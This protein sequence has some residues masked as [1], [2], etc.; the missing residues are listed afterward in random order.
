[1]EI[2]GPIDQEVISSMAEWL[3]DKPS[4]SST[5]NISGRTDDKILESFILKALKLGEFDNELAIQEQ[6]KI[7]RRV[8]QSTCDDVWSVPKTYAEA[9]RSEHAERWQ[10]A[11]R[12]ELK[13]ME[14]MRVWEVC[15][16][17]KD[18]RLTDAKWVFA[19]KHDAD[20]NP[21]KFK[22]RYV[23]KGFSQIHGVDFTDTFAP[24]A[25]FSALRILITIAAHFGWEIFSFDVTAAYL[26]SDLDHTVYVKQPTGFRLGPPG[27][28]LKCLKALYGTKQAGRCWWKFIA[29]KLRNLGFEPSQFDA[30]FYVLRR[31]KDVCMIWLH[32]DD[33]SVTGSSRSLIKEIEDNLKQHIKIKW[34]EGLKSIVGLKVDKISPHKYKLSQTQLSKKILRDNEDLI[35]SLS[36]STPM[37]D[38]TILTTI[39]KEEKE[40]INTSRYL[41]II[42]SMSY[43]AVGTR[44][45]LCFAVNFLARYAA[46]PQTE[47]WNAVKHLLQ[48]L[49][50]T[51]HAELDIFPSH[52]G[53]QPSLET[54][55]DAN[56]GGKFARS[57]YGHI[58]Q[59]CGVPISWVSRRQAC[60]ATSTCHA[61][62]MAIGAACREAVWLHS[63][64]QDVLPS[65]PPPT[66]LCD[67]TSAVHV[68]GDNSAN[69]RTRHAEREYY[70]INE[71][72]FKKKV[73]LKW[74]PANEQLADVLTKALGPLKFRTAQKQLGI[75]TSE[76]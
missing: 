26:H 67:N 21:I 56:W 37:H 19:I 57:T 72:L 34:E 63:L 10:E 39:P 31:G 11:C 15:E 25:T 27:H 68:S 6:D 35:N 30:S 13:Q 38:S 55:V 65:V 14:E 71:Q 41:S 51:Q 16:L 7:L 64:T 54:F 8:E 12:A 29:G 49:R 24:T 76:N 1:M 36:A 9:M 20:G 18:G 22:A 70:Y 47:H 66:L 45:D 2:L 5:N 3:S 61:E 62:F 46:N 73:N 75:N 58:T 44:P 4:T 60:V 32:V 23:A 69:K 43:L 50:R 74:I 28:V 48:Y 59:L 42:G 17:P 52:P 40:P 53:G 33:G